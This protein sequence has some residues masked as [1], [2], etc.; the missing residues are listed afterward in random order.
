MD[1]EPGCCW[2]CGEPAQGSCP[3]CLLAL[4]C[5]TTCLQD[6][7]A[8]HLVRSLTYDNAN[9]KT[10]NFDISDPHPAPRRNAAERTLAIEYHYHKQE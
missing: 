3:Q 6:D 8:A 2:R 9:I 4:Y 10:L 5:S 7:R 1:S